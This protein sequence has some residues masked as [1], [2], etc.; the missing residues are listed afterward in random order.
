MVARTDR[1]S[2]TCQGLNIVDCVCANGY[3]G[4]GNNCKDVDEC[5]EASLNDCDVN[6]D[7]ENNDGGYSCKCKDGYTG[8]GRTCIG[9]P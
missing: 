8:N 7:C 3:T 1:Y 4:T 9:M 6:A 2:C 5:A